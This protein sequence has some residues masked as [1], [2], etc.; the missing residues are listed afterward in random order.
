MKI[1]PLIKTVHSTPYANQRPK[2]SKKIKHFLTI[3]E[4][5]YFE[6]NNFFQI[7]P[8]ITEISQYK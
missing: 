8:V 2:H 7:R 1:M 5:I 6:F 4:F 3:R